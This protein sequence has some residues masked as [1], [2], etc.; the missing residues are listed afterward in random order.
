M[1]KPLTPEV[2]RRK[3]S[4]SL[5]VGPPNSWKTT[6]LL[7]W[8]R[9]LHVLVYP[10]EKGASSLPTDAADVHVYTWEHDVTTA[11]TP[12]AIVKAI[13]SLTVEILAGKHGPIATFAGDGLHKLYG[14]F[15]DAAA[16]GVGDPDGKERGQVFGM[17]HASFLDYLTTVLASSVPYVAMTVWDGLEK[18]DPT[19]KAKDAPKHVWPELPGTLAKRIVG[20]FGTVLYASPGRET[21]PGQFSRGTWLTRP[22]GGVWG[23]GIKLPLAIAKT[24]PTTV[25]QDWVALEALV[26]KASTSSPLKEAPKP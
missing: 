19:A 10:G 17:A 16:S 18:D 9:P 12:G 14:A 5:I 23:A 21:A 24:I 4:R 13:E 25:N 1:F 26:T 7:T 20:E 8:P 11:P 6:S 3:F 15:F 22:F 2:W